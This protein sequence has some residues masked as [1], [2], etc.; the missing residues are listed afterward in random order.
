MKSNLGLSSKQA[1]ER[2]LRD[3]ENRLAQGKKSGSLSIFAGQFKDTMVM[4][5]LAATAISALLGEWTDALIIIVIV[6]LNAILGFIQEYRAEKT[7]DA[8]KKIAAPTADVY[9]DGVLCVIPAAQLVRGDVIVFSAGAKIAADCKIIEAAS[10]E[11]DE[12]MLTGESIPVT[13]ATGTNN[14]N[15]LNQKSVCY[16]GTVATKGRGVGEVIKTGALTQMGLVSGL[17]SNIEE[18]KTP[19]QKRLAQLSKVIGITCIIICVIVS[20]A[21]IF[22]GYAL[23]DM[24]LTGVSLAV[25]A[26]PEGLPATVTISL[27]LAIRRIYKQK[28]I[29][30]KLHSVETLGCTNVICTDKTGTITQNKMKLTETYTKN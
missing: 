30:N 29:V 14:S 17:L 21:G 20:L 11:C 2:L 23:F 4:I 15:E 25:A 8:L 9:R 26:I 16:M 6:V 19:L 10:L 12:S 7:L 28:A 13:K 27:A 18:E 3:G 1:R 22:R 24:F 5:L